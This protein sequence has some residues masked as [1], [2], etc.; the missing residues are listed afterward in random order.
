[1]RSIGGKWMKIIPLFIALVILLN[2]S[3]P[4]L[5]YAYEGNL[6]KTAIDELVEFF[7]QK[8]ESVVR[9]DLYIP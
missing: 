9:E 6:L 3:V 8:L 4:I 1:M 5:S 7:D 2:I